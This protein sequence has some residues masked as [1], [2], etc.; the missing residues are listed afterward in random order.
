MNLPSQPSL[1]ENTV[2][3]IHLWKI[4]REQ[5]LVW[6]TRLDKHILGVGVY[7]RSYMIL[8]WFTVA[9]IGNVEMIRDDLPYKK[10]CLLSGIARIREGGSP[11]QICW[12]FF[13]QVIVPQIS[14]FL[15]KNHNICMFF[16]PFCHHCHCHQNHNFN[17]NFHH[18]YIGTQDVVFDVRK[19][20]LTAS[21]SER[22]SEKRSR[23]QQG[24]ASYSDCSKRD[25]IPSKV[26]VVA[27]INIIWGI[28]CPSSDPWMSHIYFEQT[29]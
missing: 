18:W 25:G 11:C 12:P 21:K 17:H 9:D 20:I 19:A 27:D 26:G 15:L 4:P 10:D 28:L 2:L 8:G 23:W 7:V 24:A 14:K 1:L 29:C 5:S 6:T 16:C 22:P 3:K 13:R